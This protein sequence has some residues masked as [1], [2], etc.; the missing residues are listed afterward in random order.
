MDLFDIVGS[1]GPWQL[2]IFLIVLFMNLVGMWQNFAIIFQTPNMDFRCVQPSSTGQH[3]SNSSSLSFDNRCEAPE[4]ENSSVLIP[5]TEWEYDTSY[6]SETIIS[7]WDLV[8][9]REWLISL[10]KST[11]M[12]GFLLS[13]IIFGQISDLIGRFPTIV[14]CYCITSV[15]TFLSLLSN[16]FTL[17]VILRF[18]QAFGRAGMTT[19]GYVLK[20][21]QGISVYISI[22]SPL[23]TSSPTTPRIQSKMRTGSPYTLTVLGCLWDIVLTVLPSKMYLE[24]DLLPMQQASRRGRGYQI[25]CR[26]HDIAESELPST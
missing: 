25:D 2:R 10:A 23:K 16:S 13:V 8:C 12:I 15:S 14:I 4:E 1:F 19:T 22:M 7:E 6:T 3:Y 18:F 24:G 5:C 11:Y 20:I 21:N 9:N 17:F 26:L